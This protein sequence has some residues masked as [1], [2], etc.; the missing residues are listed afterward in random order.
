MLIIVKAM[1]ELDFPALMQIYTE[2]N[3]EKAAEYGDGGLLHAEQSFYDYLHDVFFQ[4]PEAFYCIWQENGKSVSALRL[5]PYQD[6]WLL[7]ALETAPQHRKK[8]YA[9]A[10]MKAALDSIVGMP[11]YS[12]VSKHN[13][14]SLRTHFACGFEKHLDY[15]VFV[16][17]S[18]SHRAWTLRYA[19]K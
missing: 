12:H 3:E 1:K 9:K 8:G 16:D 4:T 14:A 15:A 11:V 6:G 7:E 13:R 18:V 5:E 19:P 17:G 2:G 10:L